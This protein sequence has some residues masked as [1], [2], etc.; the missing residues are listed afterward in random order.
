MKNVL[1]I[2]ILFELDVDD[3]IYFFTIWCFN[4]LLEDED[5]DDRND[6]VSAGS[7]IRPAVLTSASEPSERH[8]SGRVTVIRFR[9]DTVSGIINTQTRFFQ[10]GID[11]GKI[12]WGR[13]AEDVTLEAFVRV[14]VCL[15]SG[16]WFSQRC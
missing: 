4:I 13:L 5:G 1:V 3:Y 9:S 6:D 12:S 7:R 15:C 10:T 16:Q 11:K 14:F 8:H 2:F